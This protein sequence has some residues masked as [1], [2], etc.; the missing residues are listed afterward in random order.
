M[1]K[2]TPPNPATSPAIRADQC[3]RITKI[4]AGILRRKVFAHDALALTVAAEVADGLI[5]E[6]GGS[7][8]YVPI[9]DRRA[10]LTD[11]QAIEQTLRDRLTSDQLRGLA[12]T[13]DGL[14]A[15][16]AA[17][18][19]VTPR[20]VWRVLERMRSSINADPPSTL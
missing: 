8:M 4:V 14:A 9:A 17:S 16:V 15:A 20:T 19:G 12:K 7:K 3:S 11:H 2:T 1:T 5:D 13:P 6:F 10:G 18:H